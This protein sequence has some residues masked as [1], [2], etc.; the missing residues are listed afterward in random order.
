M[1]QPFCQ[2]LIYQNLKKNKK[3]T[4]DEREAAGTPIFLSQEKQLL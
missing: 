1:Q 2:I 4:V 3:P